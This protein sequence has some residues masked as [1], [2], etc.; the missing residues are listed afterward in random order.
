[1]QIEADETVIQRRL[2]NF[3]QWIRQVIFFFNLLHYK[4]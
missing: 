4:Q 2:G 3:N 1:M